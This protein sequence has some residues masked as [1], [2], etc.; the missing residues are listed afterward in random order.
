MDIYGI[1][2]Y[3]YIYIWYITSINIDLYLPFIVF[4]TSIYMV[5]GGDK[6][7][8]MTVTA[9][10]VE[11][12]LVR[13]ESSGGYRSGSVPLKIRLSQPSIHLA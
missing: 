10:L 4:I 11:L 13:Y 6:P 8:N 5:N 9:Y 1:D 12:S 7:T 3:I 2:L